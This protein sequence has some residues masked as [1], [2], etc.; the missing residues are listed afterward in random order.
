MALTPPPPPSKCKL[1]EIYFRFFVDS[2]NTLGSTP[3]PPLEK[4]YILN[5]FGGDASLSD[6]LVKIFL[7]CRHAQ[8]VKNGA[9]SH[10]TIYIDIF[11]EI[12][13]LEGHQNRCTQFDNN[14][15]NVIAIVGYLSNPAITTF[16]TKN[17]FKDG[18][19]YT[20]VCV[21]ENF[22]WDSRDESEESWMLKSRIE[23]YSFGMA[24]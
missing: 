2:S 15:I 12:L 21:V 20:L 6:P 9:S 10:K 3:L 13:N 16:F 7:R 22:N 24:L 1:F 19:D 5:L 8:I 17:N 4:V 11:P 23:V 18:C 14:P